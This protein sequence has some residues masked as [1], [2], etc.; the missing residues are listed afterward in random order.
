MLHGIILGAVG[1]ARYAG[2]DVLHVAGNPSKSAQYLAEFE[3]EVWSY[4]GMGVCLQE[5]YL[6][7]DLMTSEAWDIIGKAA[8]WARANNQ[9]L[10]D[11]HWIG[12]DPLAPQTIYGFGSW[13]PIYNKGI[14]LLKNPKETRSVTNTARLPITLTKSSDFSAFDA[15]GCGN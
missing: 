6:S 14:L 13:S 9:V 1:Q 15:A 3:H 7:P 10:Q 5:L 2:L 4:M 8:K 11:S 12:G